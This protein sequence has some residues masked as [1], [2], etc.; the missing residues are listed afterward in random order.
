M[1]LICELVAKKL[2]W[3]LS[4]LFFLLL[5][6][7]LVPV[8]AIAQV[9]YTGTT[10]T[11][12][13]GLQ[14]I[15]SPSIAKTFSFSI[16]A[17]TSVGS[18]GVMT[19]GAPN[20]EFKVAAAGT[21][22]AT[23][24]A[25]VTT[26]TVNVTFTPAYPG[27]RPGAI[28]F[29]SEAGNLGTVLGEV[30]LY[31]TGNGPEPGFIPAL[32]T[33]G[34][35]DQILTSSTIAVNAK[36]DVFIAS[37]QSGNL[38]LEFP[39]GSPSTYLQLT[40]N[41][42]MVQPFGLAMDG[43]G[44][45]YVT[46]NA[47]NRVATVPVG[48]GAATAIIPVASGKGLNGPTGITIDGSGNIFIADTGNN[49]IVKLPS[50]GGS[51]IAITPSVN[52]IGLNAPQSVAT[53]IS[54]NLYIADTSNN[55][56]VEVPSGGGVA[57]AIAPIVNGI[58][59]SSPLSV[60]VDGGG[61]LFISDN[62]N[63]RVIDV[64]AGAGAPIAYD[65]A[66]DGSALRFNT[67]ITVN[68]AGDL[69]ILDSYQ[70]R[71]VQ[72]HRSQPAPI[73]FPMAAAV[74][75]T[76]TADGTKTVQ[77]LNI[78]NAPMAVSSVSFPADFSEVGGVTNTCATTTSLSA[79]GHCN[80][81]IEF[82]PDHAGTLTEDVVITDDALNNANSKQTI[83][84]S[85]A[86][87]GSPAVLTSPAQGSMLIGP[88]VTFSW[89]DVTGGTGYALW[90]GTTGVGSD[91]LHEGG[92][93]ADLSTSVSGLPLN[94]QTIYARLWTNSNGALVS[95][96]TVY[97]AAKQAV[98]TSPTPATMIV[99]PSS[100]FV[101]TAASNATGYALW[102]GTTG[103]GSHEILEGGV[104]PATSLTLNNLPTSGETIY[105]RL[106][107][108]YNG[109]L[110]YTD[111]V[112]T[113]AQARMISPSS[114][115][116][117]TGP[118]V[119]FSWTAGTNASGYALWVGTAGVGSH[120]L[121]ETGFHTSTSLT[122]SNLPV[123]GKTVYV[124]LWTMVSGFEIYNDYTFTATTQ[125][126]MIYPANIFFLAGPVM[127]FR[128]SA[129]TGA[130]GYAL[131]LGTT[132]AGSHDLQEGGVH[133][134]TSEEV[135]GLPTN[136]EAVYA[137]LWTIFNGTQIY[138]DYVYT[139]T[140]QAAMTSPTPGTTLSGVSVT[141]TWSYGSGP[142]GYALWVGTTGAGS[143]DLVETGVSTVNSLTVNNLPINNKMIYVRLWSSY[144]GDLAYT[145]YIYTAASA[146]SSEKMQSVEDL[147]ERP[148]QATTF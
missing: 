94:G 84:V 4:L 108:S 99:G 66:A 5:L 31:G 147:L 82:M 124:R 123:N 113:G 127:N 133:T 79:G 138:A 129:S 122:V 75:A 118:S 6:T 125:A 76:D 128:W 46:D 90:L 13:F 69:F 88:S 62:G 47:H 28:V 121:L 51:A 17:G 14:S 39:A 2:L 85:G 41:G 126:A 44:N 78:G 65:P 116:I 63:T 110:A 107:T 97:I 57:V 103:T 24:Y 130:T 40:I 117:L 15:G 23:S 50:G 70:S 56:V 11:Q 104:H 26:C 48:G 9:T 53:D 119:A 1:Q 19:H 71:Y 135:D 7:V 86:T 148:R 95:T 115:S 114:G 101:W 146:A 64:Q 38:I 25:S 143:H 35:N 120:D 137:R 106:W 59:L 87:H 30:P 68:E 61:N 83:S 43:A 91:D 12:N 72:V 10:A 67:G 112:Y 142:N 80:I 102:L 33:S 134:T 98:L 139:A 92:I 132:G 144:S 131:W 52:G 45:L 29:F 74:G 89:S 100:T 32:S 18:I 22:T 21:C 55:R 140:T 93:H 34:A 42:L 8:N 58:A 3:P 145:D 109:T 96:D 37:I 73:N 111:Y 60:V 16:A 105:A 20:L 81:P 77:I 136:G 36:G 49:R 54:G 141:F 27:S